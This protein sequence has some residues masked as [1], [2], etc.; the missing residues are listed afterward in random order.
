MSMQ[1]MNSFLEKAE[2]DEGV[3]ARLV[4]ILDE[5]EKDAIPPMIV[6]LAND[7]GYAITE[8]DVI[9]TRQRFEKAMG[10]GDVEDGDL[11]DE[12]LEQVSGGISPALIDGMIKLTGVAVKATGK[13]TSV[14]IDR[15][16]NRTVD[17][18]GN[19]FKKW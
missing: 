18:I 2:A 5:N 19:F 12:D 16:L 4:A 14:L 17:D 11:S 1:T 15:G 7:N 13:I 6:E 8:E 3:A 10:S 9:E